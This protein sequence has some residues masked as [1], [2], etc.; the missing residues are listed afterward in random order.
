MSANTEP[1]LPCEQVEI[2]EIQG[3]TAPKVL[4]IK[5]TSEL[6]DGIGEKGMIYG[7]TYTFEVE[8]YFADI[9]PKNKNDIKWDCTY[10]SEDGKAVIIEIQQTGDKIKFKIDNLEMLGKTVSFH[11]YIGE[12][13]DEASLDEWVHY[14]FRWFNKDLF[15]SQLRIRK[16]DASKIN[17]HHT[18]LCGVA[19]VLYFLAKDDTLLFYHT[20][21]EFFRT[22]Q[23]K[24]NE[25]Q[26][27]P[28]KN[29]YEMKPT[30]DNMKYPRYTKYADG[31]PCVPHQLMDE[32]DWI[33]LAGTRSSENQKYEGKNGEN[34]DGI[35][36][37]ST[38][39][40]LTTQLYGADKYESKISYIRNL[41][42]IETL[43]KIQMEY[44]LGYHIAMLIDSDMLSGIIST[45]G[46]FNQYHW[47]A[48]EGDLMI[49]YVNKEY[50]F[51]YF[52]WK[53][54]FI[55]GK[56]NHSL[57]KSNFYGYIKFKKTR[58]IDSPIKNMSF[59]KNKPLLG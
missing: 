1:V 40:K 17:Q 4:S 34:F 30:I 7:K 27:N 56:F 23:C 25:F 39:K 12:K 50:T 47:I 6:D 15:E 32:A 41:E 3:M 45:I 22:G 5:I 38:M 31:T 36:W 29:L 55:K 13:D 21:V 19:V 44:D 9:K 37:E 42:A 24:I 33:I 52:C 26:L 14:R 2:L 10:T 59:G 46:C 8:S 54:L 48:Y 11:A 58:F 43:Q 16:N 28:N 51:S 49:D 18:P 20:Y 53:N 57:F 35:N